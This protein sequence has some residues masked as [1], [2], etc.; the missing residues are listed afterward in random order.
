VVAERV[1]AA[2][3]SRGERAAQLGIGPMI[4]AVGDRRGASEQQIERG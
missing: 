4:G 2:I 3:D 1:F